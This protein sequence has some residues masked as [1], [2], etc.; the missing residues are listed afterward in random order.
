MT[1]HVFSMNIASG[2]PSNER[3]CRDTCLVP[4]VSVRQTGTT[5][6]QSDDQYHLFFIICLPRLVILK[7]LLVLSLTILK[8]NWWNHFQ[9]RLKTHIRI[10]NDAETYV[11]SLL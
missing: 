7:L 9:S 2:G 11:F 8:E 4:R 1:V 6:L 10:V 5:V 3:P